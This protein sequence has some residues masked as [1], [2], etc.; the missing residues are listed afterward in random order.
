M[1]DIP[2]FFDFSNGLGGTPAYLLIDASRESYT[3]G[4]SVTS[5]NDFGTGAKTFTQ[6]SV[7]NRPTF[8]ISGGVSGVSFGGSTSYMPSANSIPST[9]G[10]LIVAFQT[11][12]TAFA[13]QG[14]QVL[15]SSA[16][17]G[18]ADNW[19]EVGI[20]SSGRMYCEFNASGTKNR[21]RGSTILS[22]S[23]KYC[24]ALDFAGTDYWMQI[25][26]T[27]E[28]PITYLN[29]DT[30]APMSFKWFGDVSGPD[31]VV[32]GGTVTSAGLVRPFQGLIY[33]ARL[34]AGSIL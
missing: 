4:Q 21:A 8:S 5:L 34:W 6:G 19:F 33:T 20:D 11:G 24:F 3:N 29:S 16:D 2:V 27:E 28:N 25:G 9:Q 18:T 22:Q 23:T 30:S 15:F 17:T 1:L 26:T 12:A 7:G 10:T 14:D 32:I 13:T 31:N